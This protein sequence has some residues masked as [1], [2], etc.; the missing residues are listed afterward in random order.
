M[1]RLIPQILLMLIVLQS[2]LYNTLLVAGYELNSD[3][4]ASE[5]CENQALPELHCDGKCFFAR[6][7][8]LADTP[9]RES[10]APVYL[11]SLPLFSSQYCLSLPQAVLKVLEQS[12]LPA[13]KEIL[14]PSPYLKQ[15]LP[16]PRV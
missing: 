2:Q 16:P 4:Y 14:Y 3:Y 6:Q 15:V 5:L 10:E 8:G 1:Y 12:H 7:M 9:S 13:L 11:P